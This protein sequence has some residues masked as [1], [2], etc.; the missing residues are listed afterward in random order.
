MRVFNILL[1]VALLTWSHTAQAVTVNPDALESRTPGGDYSDTQGSGPNITSSQPLLAGQTTVRGMLNLNC[2]N[3]DCSDSTGL[4]DPADAFSVTLGQNQVLTSLILN[5]S[6]A[7]N[8]QQDL[9]DVFFGFNLVTPPGLSNLGYAKAGE[10]VNESIFLSPSQ[11]FGAGDY[12]LFVRAG[13]STADFQG[14]VNWSLTATIVDTSVSAVPLP[15]G[16]PLLLA[17]FATLGMLRRK[18]RSS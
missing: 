3:A 5:I 6:S 1:A 2:V 8:P 4:R 13:R 12:S 7:A 11:T 14:K 15:A 18:Q 16:L 17:G 9:S 10:T